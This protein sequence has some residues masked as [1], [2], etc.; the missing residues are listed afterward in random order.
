VDFLFSGLRAQ[1]V[2]G[3]VSVVVLGGLLAPASALATSAGGRDL[4]GV[5]TVNNT[6]GPGVPGT[7]DITNGKGGAFDGTGYGGGWIVRGSVSGNSVHYTVSGQGSYISTVHGT[8]NSDGTRIT[9]S[10]TDTNGASG[11]A[12]LEKKGPRASITVEASAPVFSKVDGES[13]VHVGDVVAVTVKV[14]ASGADFTDV[15]LT[16]GGL[17]VAPASCGSSHVMSKGNAVVVTYAPPLAS[18]FPLDADASRTFEFKLRAHHDGVAGLLVNARGQTATGETA[19]ASDS[20]IVEVAP[21][22]LTRDPVVPPNASGCA[23]TS[24]EAGN[25]QGP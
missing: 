15:S 5:W 21:G 16:N 3:F 22:G 13:T 24:A 9:Y 12:Y 4:S 20:I 17:V 2:V 10:W 1:L 18:G 14:S 8:L 7:L 19:Q 11:T 25:P 23:S 6:S